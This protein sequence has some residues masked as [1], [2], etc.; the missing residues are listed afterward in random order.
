MVQ[1]VQGG[2]VVPLTKRRFMS[3]GILAMEESF[4]L[5]FEKLEKRRAD[6]E[7]STKRAERI[8]NKWTNMQG[9]R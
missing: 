8:K 2:K 5:E 9:Y 1:S 6:Y 4:Q 3:N 7:A